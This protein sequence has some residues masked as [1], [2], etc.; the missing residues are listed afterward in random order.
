MA[1]QSLLP[2]F[3]IDRL[4]TKSA[5][6]ALEIWRDLRIPD[7]AGDPTF[8]EVGALWF[9]DF[10]Y[11]MFLMKGASRVVREAFVMT[12]KKSGA[13]TNCAALMLTAL[14]LNSRP[15][16]VF[17]L[18]GV[19]QAVAEIAFCMM[20]ETI[21]LDDKLSALLSVR[22]PREI[23]HLTT[24]AR[25]VVKSLS[26][27][28]L[29]CEYLS[30]ALIDGAQLFRH[31]RWADALSDLRSALDGYEDSFLILN[32]TQSREFPTGPFARELMRAR[33][34]RD[35]VCN[36]GVLPLIY[37]PPEGVDWQ[38]PKNFPLL[39]PGVGR[40]VAAEFLERSKERAEQ[41]GYLAHWAAQ[42]LNV[43]TKPM[44]AVS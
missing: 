14:V 27:E 11:S 33:A 43:E 15:N 36:A 41:D 4:S 37:E 40:T 34:I 23:H 3:P 13:S 7:V 29:A 44:A 31:E 22:H 19:T 8:G 9:K 21:S 26:S 6:R 30:G 10:I 39:H 12:P 17:G 16:A 2:D 28:T 5:D 1:G 25:V 32:A 38:D 35:G 20:K 24:G 18:F 42:W